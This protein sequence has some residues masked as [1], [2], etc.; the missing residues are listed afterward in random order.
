[1]LRFQNH[2]PHG[3]LDWLDNSHRFAWQLSVG[4]HSTAEA[5]IGLRNRAGQHCEGSLRSVVQTRGT[6]FRSRTR[7][8]DGAQRNSRCPVLM[9][10]SDGS[11]CEAPSGQM[12]IVAP[13]ANR[14]R[15]AANVSSFFETSAPWSR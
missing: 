11:S 9:G 15:A 4:L 6:I 5:L 1:M 8:G 3:A 14:R 10:R 2:G 7:R 13:A 12:P